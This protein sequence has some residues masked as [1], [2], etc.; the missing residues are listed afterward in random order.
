MPDG[1]RKLFCHGIFFPFGALAPRFGPLA[2]PGESDHQLSA[3]ASSA[4]TING[5]DAGYCFRHRFRDL[6]RCERSRGIPLQEFPFG[7]RYVH[8]L[9]GLEADFAVPVAANH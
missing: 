1:C 5:F 4:P 2:L 7:V 8:D 9:A 6:F 3:L